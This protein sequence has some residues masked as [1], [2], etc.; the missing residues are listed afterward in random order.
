MSR[1]FWIACGVVLAG[2]LGL[3]GGGTLA[4]RSEVG[5]LR[6]D[7]D[8][9]ARD[10]G[11][12]AGPGFDGIVNKSDI[13]ATE[14]RLGVLEEEEK[15]LRDLMRSHNMRLD[16]EVFG[17]PPPPRHDMALFRVWLEEK[18]IR[19]DEMLQRA[20]VLIGPKQPG[21]R[22]DVSNW[23]LVRRDD[24]PR[25]L[26]EYV[27][28]SE[29]CRA[30]SEAKAAVPGEEG[31]RGVDQLR[32]IRF[33]SDAGGRFGAEPAPA[34]TEGAP[35]REHAVT[36]SFVAHYNVA[37]EALRLMES[38]KRGLFVVRLARVKRLQEM[39]LSSRQIAEL[40]SQEKRFYERLKDGE[41]HDPPVEVELRMGLIEFIAAG[42]A[43]S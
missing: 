28:T 4:V 29:I 32:S 36:V 33:G 43:E 22:G 24:V 6:Q 26:R 41:A 27:V 31:K 19:R 35:Y 2:S 20:G 7:L 34:A 21:E 17:D 9:R 40:P 13:D 30:L 3:W 42:E 16:D 38:S 39:G 14:K 18:Y 37:L 12:L 15:R 1:L 25:I 11:R 23:G 5:S 8:L 10:L